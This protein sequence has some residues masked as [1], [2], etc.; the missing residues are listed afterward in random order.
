M[1]ITALPTPPSRQDPANFNDRAD[2]FLGALPL[3]QTEANALET[4]VN[5]RE[6]NTVAASNAAL[7]A[8]NVVKWVSG[9]TYAEGAVVWSPINALGYRRITASGSGTTDP[10]LDTTNY[11]QVNGTGDVSTTGNQTIA[12]T[13]TFSSNIAG[14]ITGNAATATAP[15]SGGSFIT[16][17]NIGSQSVSSATSATTAQ[18][19]IDIA[20][21]VT[22]ALRIVGKAARRLADYPVLTVSAADTHS[23]FTGS[24]AESLAT[25]TTSSTEVV[26]YRYTISKYTGSLRF[27]TNQRGGSYGEGY[28]L[29]STTSTLRIFKNGS[30]IQTYSQTGTTS[31]TRTNDISI[32]PGD[33]IE[34]RHKTNDTL[35]SAGISST[36]ILG[37]DGYTTRELLLQSTEVNNV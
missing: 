35:G 18:N 4:N 27:R 26:A 17:T 28:A 9:T 8:V 1:P 23:A 21:G 20:N 30:L 12:G 24:G 19:A 15:A 10:S 11:K 31:V 25:T 13:K 3:F 6:Q 2:T 16:S 34:W 36:V 7:A 22:G 5:T 29:T 33:V 14:S 32:V 37:T